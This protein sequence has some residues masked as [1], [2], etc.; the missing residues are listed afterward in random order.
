MKLNRISLLL[1]LS[2]GAS[3]PLLA[4]TMQDS[5]QLE[6][7]PA[8]VSPFTPDAALE[9]RI[10]ALLSTMTVAQKVAQVIQP[11][12]RD[13]TVEDMRRYGFGSYLNGG[14]AFPGNNTR[15]TAADWVALADK[16]HQAAMDSS[17]DGIAIPPIWGTD[18]VH[19]HGNVFGATLF[20]HN[21]GLGAARDPGLIADIA[22]ATAKE[23]RATG[24]DWVFAPTVAMV[25]DLRWGRSYEGYARDPQLIRDYGHAFVEGMQGKVGDATWLQGNHT[26][27]TVKHFIGD[28]GTQDGND[29]GDTRID[30]QTLIERHAQGYVGAVAA[31]VQT[32]MASFNSWN[33]EKLHGSRYLLTE[34]LK[35]RLGFDGLVVGDW[36][37]H[38]FVPGCDGTSCPA[39][40]NAGVDIL[41]APGDAWKPLYDNTLAQAQSGDIPAAR[42]DDAVRRILRVKIRGGLFDAP[43]PAK[44]LLA[45]EQQQI[46]SE[47]HRA[48]A[49]QAVRQSLVLLKNNDQTLPIAANARVLVI[50]DGADNIPKQSGG[51]SMT[52]QGTEVQN[53]DFPGATSIFAGL[54]AG[55]K[56]GGGEARLSVDGTIPEGFEPDLV[57][58]VYGEDP[59]AE[60]NGDRDNLEY[61]RG[62]KRDLAM[63]RAIKAIKTTKGTGLPL[64]SVF[65]SGRPLWMNPEINLSDAFVAAWLP[66]TEGA[67]VADVLLATQDGKPGFDFSGRLPFPWPATPFD[68]GYAKRDSEPLFAQGEGLAYANPRQLAKLDELQN[69]LNAAPARL[70]IFDLAIK[71]PWRLTVSDGKKL[72]SV[73]GGIWQ[74][75]ALSVRSVNWQVQEDARRF[76]LGAPAT[77]SFRDDFP[78]DLRRFDP[79]TAVL[80]FSMALQSLPEGG[81]LTLSMACEKS[82]GRAVDIAGHTRADGQWRQFE[83]PLRCLALGAN[84]LAQVLSPMTLTL[85]QGGTLTLARIAIEAGSNSE[86]VR[87]DCDAIAAAQGQ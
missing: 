24:I 37:G 64:V 18:A 13:F 20:P 6:R 68:D 14:G 59:Y 83:M 4:D 69:K 2:L 48:L 43:S 8:K 17:E 82:C 45:G 21:I 10:D 23:V 30:E 62:D 52:W 53:Q 50:G 9:A 7:W 72:H 73:S 39:A 12:I 67:G 34:V 44:R 66:G 15:A 16:L 74:Q 36:L 65:L 22:R 47:A 31:G 71:A 32:V 11:E 85:S 79:Q 87:L 35:N 54:V 51:W 26:I 46:G 25:E 1:A 41:M 76:S 29:R 60:G 63:L 57:L 55:L 5:L 86:A 42:L 19:G 58:A 77:L 28:G 49:R 75:D 56:A 40:I 78:M 33:G 84:E 27:A 38:A 70:P 3:A 81:A 61:Q 80:S